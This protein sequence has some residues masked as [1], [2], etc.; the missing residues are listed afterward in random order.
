MIRYQESVTYTCN[1]G[2]TLSG[3]NTSTC[4]A[5]GTILTPSCP[6]VTCQVPPISNGTSSQT[7]M[8]RYQ[9]SVTY[10]CNTGYTLRGVNTSKCAADGTILTPS[11]IAVNCTVPNIT[12]GQQAVSEISFQ[13]TANYSCSAH[14]V[15]VG[16]T[17]PACQANRTLTSTPTCKDVTCQ[18][19]T[20]SNG[21]S[22]Q[23][24]MIRY[25]ESVTYT[26]NTGY[27]LSGV[28]TSTCA[29]NGTILTPSC[30]AVTCQVPPI[31]NGT[32]SQT[33]M[34]RYQASVTYTCNTG[35]T[36]SGVNTSTCAADGTI[37]TPSC[38][39]VNCTVPNITNGQQAVSEISFQQTANYSCSAHHVLVGETWPAC[40]ANRTL[41]STPTCKD[42]TCQV[43]TISNGT[44]SQAGMIRY[45]ESVTYT[46]NTGYTLSGVNTSKCAADGTILTPSCLAVTCQVPPIS[47]GTSSQT[48]MIRYQASVTYTCNTG[49]TLRGVNTSTCAADGTILTPSCIAVNCT[50]PNIT[51]GQQAVSEISFQQTANYSCS[52]HHVLVGE[53]RPACQANRTLTSTPTCKDVTCQVPTISNGTSSQ[54][55]MIRYQE[56]VT[57][58]CNTGY[59]L[60]GVN[61][62]KC[63]AN[64]TIL[65]PSCLGEQNGINV[66]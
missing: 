43:P 11:C 32:S 42:V 48:G 56:S 8:I 19:P 46:C 66:S 31:S 38:L 34:I 64:G 23:A 4:A 36:L 51:N 50:V 52:A 59:T 49:Y 14:H 3:V 45:Q 5:N 54:A 53:S 10:T 9:A 40:Q 13:Q 39:A 22:S 12:N 16:E 33:G 57:Y 58:T 28:N 24:G 55:G 27:T 60:S 2:Y 1:T 30:L 63:A 6:A 61:T 37:L 35:Y 26:C 20:I 21:T 15:L 29:A 44:S 62:S 18:V 17:R 47:N 25:Q 7:G 41:T 65:T